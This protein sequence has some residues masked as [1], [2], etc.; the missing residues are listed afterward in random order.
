GGGKSRDPQFRGTP[1]G[2]VFRQGGVEKLAVPST[3]GSV[4]GPGLLFIEND[5]LCEGFAVLVRSRHVKGLGFS[6][7]GKSGIALASS[8]VIVPDLCGLVGIY[9]GRND[10]YV[11]TVP[12]DRHGLTLL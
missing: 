9:L 5:Q 1:L 11:L 7:L 8:S 12:L 10:R 6:V 4:D 2:N 3:P